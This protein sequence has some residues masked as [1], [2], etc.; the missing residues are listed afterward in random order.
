M[1]KSALIEREEDLEP[2]P[3][4][5]WRGRF[6]RVCFL[7]RVGAK[8]AAAAIPEVE[9]P[10]MVQYAPYIVMNRRL[11]PLL[12][13]P[14]DQAPIGLV[15][16]LGPNATLGRTVCVLRERPGLVHHNAVS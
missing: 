15:S 12:F 14:D 16:C 1:C 8:Y 11:P 10:T 3:K 13:Q 6:R 9:F 2:F 5:V 7:D 4:H